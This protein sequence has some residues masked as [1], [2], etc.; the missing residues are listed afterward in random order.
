M[1]ALRHDWRLKIGAG[2]GR[3]SVVWRQV[4]IL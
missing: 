3:I 2:G 4:P 1:G